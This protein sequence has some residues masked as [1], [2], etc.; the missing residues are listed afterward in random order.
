MALKKSNP[1]F[2][3]LIRECEGVEPKVYARYGKLL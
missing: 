2:P 1:K 3:V